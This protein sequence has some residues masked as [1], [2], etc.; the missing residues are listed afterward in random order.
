MTG[1]KVTAQQ[2]N[3]V[4][5]ASTIYLIV[6]IFGF[7]GFNATS[8]SA[9]QLNS[10]YNAIAALVGFVSYFILKNF[11]KESEK[12]TFGLERFI[13][14]LTLVEGLLIFSVSAKCLRFIHTVNFLGG[15]H[16]GLLIQGL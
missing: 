6:S 1:T 3:F 14:L 8:S 7:I 12:F 2:S 10:Y 15:K 4:L 5:L 16:Q 11:H 13:P 9:I